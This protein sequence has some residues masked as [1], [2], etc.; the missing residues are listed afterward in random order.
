MKESGFSAENIAFGMGGALLQ[1]NFESSINRDSFKFA[2]K[3]S[4]IRRASTIFG[5]KKE[6]VTDLSKKSKEGRLD[7][8]KDENG[9]Y[10]TIKLDENYALGEYHPQTQLKTYYENGQILFEQSLEQI[11]NIE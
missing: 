3:C 11:R 9:N 6:P 8:I 7:L 4:A 1:G 2:I 10:K 5:V